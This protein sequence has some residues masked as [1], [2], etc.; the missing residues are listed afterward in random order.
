[1]RPAYLDIREMG[2]HELP[3]AWK[4]PALEVHRPRPFRKDAQQRETT[5]AR[6][7][8]GPLRT[9]EGDLFGGL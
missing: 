5:W 7:S 6:S 2:A 1:M 9:M 3:V 8:W 4:A